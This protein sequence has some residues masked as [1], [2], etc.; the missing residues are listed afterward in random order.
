MTVDEERG[1]GAVAGIG[2]RIGA[3]CVDSLLSVA[4]ALVIGFRPGEA[5]Y[6][7]TVAVAFLL[8]EFAFVATV[9][10]TPGMRAVGAVVVRAADGQRAAARWVA[11]RTLLLATIVPALVVD[12]S[13]RAMHDRA[14]GTVMIRTR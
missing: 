8:V 2:A 4:A 12:A 6:G 7:I 14:A 10:Q 3:F 5:G 13:G 1:A 9:A 11:L